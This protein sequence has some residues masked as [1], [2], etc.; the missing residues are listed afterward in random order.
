MGGL[1]TDLYYYVKFARIYPDF[2]TFLYK[3]FTT[4]GKLS[5]R[6]VRSEILVEKPRTDKKQKRV[7]AFQK[8]KLYYPPE[9]MALKRHRLRGSEVS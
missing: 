4:S 5:W 8:L 9:I 1:K 2:D 7:D 6:Y 3:F